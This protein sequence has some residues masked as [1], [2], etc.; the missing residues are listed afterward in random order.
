MRSGLVAAFLF[1]LG[2]AVNLYF[3]RR[4]FFP[5]DQSLVFDG[6]WR[7]LTGQVPFRDFAAPNGLTPAVMQLPFFAV[8][9]VTW[10]AM[11]LHAAVI[12]GLLCV[13]V[14]ALLRVCDATQ[15][16]AAGFAAASAFFFY[17]PTGTPFTDQHSF[18]FMTLMF[19]AAAAGTTAQTA[20]AARLAWATVPTLFLLGLLSCQIPTAFGAVWIAGWVAL[21]PHRAVGWIGALAVGT[22]ALAAAIVVIAWALHIDLRSGF[23]HVIVAPIAQGGTRTPTPG[24]APPLRMIAGTLRRLP[25]W[26]NLWS[27]WVAIAAV[28][29]AALAARRWAK[30]RVTA[31][32]LAG[33]IV[34]TAGFVAYSKTQIDAGLG[35]A[36]LMAG[37]AAIVLRQASETIP[38]DGLWRRR[39]ALLAAVVIAV[40]AGRDTLRFINTVDRPGLDTKRYDPQ[41]AIAAEGRLP[42]G[43]GFLHWSR[44]A[45]FYEPDELSALVGYLRDADGGFL[46]IGDSSILYGLTGKPSPNPALWFDPGLTM[47]PPD[48]P[49][50]EAY[51]SELIRRIRFFHVRRLVIEGPRTWAGI[52]LAQFPNLQRLAT[53]T[54]CGERT[55]GE[56]R[57]LELCSDL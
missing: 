28:P 37:L 35:L 5:L 50:F 9:G 13:A 6:A 27:L 26:A 45:S 49:G 42:A 25:L 41:A 39:A 20:G 23:M 30:W 55:F 56:V 51:E 17:P 53:S 8:F 19:L 46:L 43:L 14:Y 31:W 2:V 21:N 52:S 24:L 3:G 34:T 15:W 57:V 32:T 44:G 29:L 11:C 48:S 54:A 40:A 16:E 10:F 1:A 38:G 47:P 22:L 7:M 33:L 36:M 18:F 4:G 12:N